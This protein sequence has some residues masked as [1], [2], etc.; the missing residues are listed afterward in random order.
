MSRGTDDLSRCP[1][2]TPFEMDMK[3]RKGSHASFNVGEY[4]HE[5]RLLRAILLSMDETGWSYDRGQ[6]GE[7]EWVA[8]ESTWS[9]D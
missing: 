3:S 8:Y 2:R 1:S 6:F 9:A 5:S 4:R 7:K